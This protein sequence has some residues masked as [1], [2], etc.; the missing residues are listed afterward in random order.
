VK[1]WDTSAL[2][3]LLVPEAFTGEL[4]DLYSGGDG[5]FAWWGT[6]VECA[7]AIARLERQEQ[8]QTDE[9][10]ELFALLDEMVR[11][12]HV[13]PPSEAVREAARPFLRAHDLRAADA[14]QL[15]AAHVAAEN[16]RRTLP[17]VCL[18]ARLGEAAQREGFQVIGR[19]QL[20]GPLP[21]RF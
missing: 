20:L 1:F 3:P 21:R 2:V 15:A 16:R 8:L 6:E 12:W 17:L 7:S 13:I 9:A 19:A 18:D 11:T 10:S 14:L 5:V 4:E